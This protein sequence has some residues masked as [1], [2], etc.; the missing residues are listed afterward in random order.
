MPLPVRQTLAL[1]LHPGLEGLTGREMHDHLH[2][3]ADVD[4]ALDHPGDAVLAGRPGLLQPD[5][6]GSD[7][8]LD[9][10]ARV[11]VALPGHELEL[12]EPDLRLPTGVEPSPVASIR[13]ET[14]RKSAT[15]AVVGSS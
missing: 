14:P 8:D 4:D 2:D 11:R 1:V 3:R 5:A 9:V 12:A 10:S 6:L 7:H 15:Y 13:F